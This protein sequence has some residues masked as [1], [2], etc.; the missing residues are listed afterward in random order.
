MKVAFVT[1]LFFSL[2]LLSH[3]ADDDGIS[4]ERPPKVKP[5]KPINYFKNG[6]WQV[7]SNFDH[8]AHWKWQMEVING[9][10]LVEVG[11]EGRPVQ[12]HCTG[13]CCDPV[14]LDR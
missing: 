3:L 2:Q 6:K 4:M 8:N 13:D 5:E 7:E 12:N 11:Q 14:L 9:S 10:A 1:A